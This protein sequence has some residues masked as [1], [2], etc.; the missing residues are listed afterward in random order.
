[1]VTSAT[2]AVTSDEGRHTTVSIMS[3]DGVSIEEISDT[4]GNESHPRH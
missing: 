2:E 4:V 3:S 1:M